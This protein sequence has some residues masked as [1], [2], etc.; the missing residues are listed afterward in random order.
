MDKKT[1]LTNEDLK[2]K[3]GASNFELVNYAIKLAENM[4]KTSRD[5][6]VKSDM[7]NRALLVLEEIIEGKDQFDTVNE[8]QKNGENQFNAVDGTS[9]VLVDERHSERR[10]K[11][12]FSL[13]DE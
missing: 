3:F 9:V 4:I 13:S 6:R 7:Q 5:A 2:K 10:G 8:T 11:A 12:K 1:T